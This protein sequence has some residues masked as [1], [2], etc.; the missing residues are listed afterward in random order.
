MGIQTAFDHIREGEAARSERA[1]GGV[2]AGSSTSAAGPVPTPQPQ[3][4]APS[5]LRLDSIRLHDFRLHAERPLA[6]L[7]DAVLLLGPNASGKTSVIEAMQLLLSGHT[8]S[9]VRS[10]H[11]IRFGSEQALVEGAVSGSG[12][13]LG[14]AVRIQPGKRAYALNGKP[15]RIQDV[16]GILPTV[17]FTPDELMLVKGSAGL[18]RDALD[19]FGAELS[20]NYAAVR[21]DYAKLIRQKNRA[22]KDEAADW[23]L[24]SLDEVL[25]KVGA[26]LIR[27][28]RTLIDLLAP[29]F[30]ELYRDIAHADERVGIAYAPFGDPDCQAESREDLAASMIALLATRRPEER[31]R[32]RALVGPHADGLSFLI[33]G[34]EAARFASQGQ[35]RTLVLAFE[36][37]GADL[38]RETLGQPPLL[39]LDD[40]MSELDEVRRRYFLGF[41][42]QGYQTVITST[43]REYFPP[44]A[45]AALDVREVP[46]H[47]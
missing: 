38:I 6:G 32:A 19:S 12:R 28:R 39:L 24:D 42:S 1:S 5:T 2:D 21:Q 17:A 15:K 4:G 22:L 35:Q 36:L 43:T 26:Q 9:G 16:R 44:A 13:E 47:G 11:L 40:V 46:F 31:S 27:H 37:A 34:H 20:R 33:E 10:E 45:L 25:V 3:H 7:G 30:R 18:R 23:V 29:R 41:V 14:F 8:F